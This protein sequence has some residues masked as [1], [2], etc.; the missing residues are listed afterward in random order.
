[1][2]TF[3]SLSFPMLTKSKPTLNLFC[4]IL[5]WSWRS[6]CVLG[7]CGVTDISHPVPFKCDIR[8]RSEEAAALI[9]KAAED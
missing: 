2:L 8:P 5:C 3:I 7:I 6:W 1:M 4:F 9:K